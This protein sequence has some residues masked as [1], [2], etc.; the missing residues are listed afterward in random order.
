MK[1]DN[2]LNEAGLINSIKQDVTKIADP[3]I[4]GL[5][6]RKA[7]L[8]K[9]IATID[10]Q[11]AQAQGEAA[12]KAAATAQDVTQGQITGDNGSPIS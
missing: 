2:T 9:Q 5:M 8:M 12:K 1:F 10:M 3:R 6:N 7:N 4:K 11:I